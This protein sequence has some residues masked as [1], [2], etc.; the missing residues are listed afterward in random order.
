[1]RRDDC[2]DAI[3]RQPAANQRGT[4]PSLRQTYRLTVVCHSADSSQV[5]AELKRLFVEHRLILRS[6][7]RDQASF[8]FVRISALLAS[9]IAE[10]SALVRIVNLLASNPSIRRL[11]WETVPNG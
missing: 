5:E 4:P 2:F 6:L 11:Q 8:A 10:R 7:L 1:M 9:S 3:T